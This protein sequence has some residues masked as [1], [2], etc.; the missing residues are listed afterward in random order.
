M[1][2][3]I[4][5]IAALLTALTSLIAALAGLVVLMISLRTNR[6]VHE[7][8]TQ[9]DGLATAL[10]DSKLAEGKAVGKAEGLEIGRAEVK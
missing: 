5:Q 3:T 9:T 1:N 6:V 2:E 4:A 10:A 8:K 7:V